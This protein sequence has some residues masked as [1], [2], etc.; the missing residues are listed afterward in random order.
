TAHPQKWAYEDILEDVGSIPPNLQVSYDTMIDVIEKSDLILSFS[1]TAI[2]EALILGK[3]CDVIMDFGINERLGTS[4]Y[5]ESG[6]LATF[7]EIIKDDLPRH[8][9]SWLKDEMDAPCLSEVLEMLREDI[10]ACSQGKLPFQS[11][12]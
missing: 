6:L 2:I 4:Y 7:D 8:N 9:D 5:I 1:S 3:R 11:A 12:S 10:S